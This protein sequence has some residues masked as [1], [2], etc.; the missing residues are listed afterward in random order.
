MLVNLSTLKVARSRSF[1]MS[2]FIALCQA[3]SVIYCEKVQVY[4]I[5]SFQVEGSCW[6]ASSVLAQAQKAEKR[7]ELTGHV[8]CIPEVWSLTRHYTRCLYP[9]FWLFY[10]FETFSFVN[11]MLP[12]A[13]VF[14]FPWEINSGVVQDG[15]SV[16]TFGRWVVLIYNMKFNCVAPNCTF[17]IKITRNYIIV[18]YNV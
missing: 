6:T 2:G 15:A 18:I 17:L 16:R 1:L 14:Y 12:A 13:A 3:E 10:S 5:T 7:Q 11:K 9:A 8:M 4:C